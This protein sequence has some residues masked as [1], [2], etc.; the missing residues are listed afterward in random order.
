M[1]KSHLL[2][3]F[4][5][6]GVRNPKLVRVMRM[7]HDLAHVICDDVAYDP[8]FNAGMRKLMEARDCFDRLDENRGHSDRLTK[9]WP[10]DREIDPVTGRPLPAGS[11]YSSARSGVEHDR[12][13]AERH[14]QAMLDSRRADRL[15]SA[16]EL[17]EA[18]IEKAAIDLRDQQQ[19]GAIEGDG[20]EQTRASHAAI[21]AEK[22]AANG[23]PRT[24]IHPQDGRRSCDCDMCKG[25]RSALGIA[26]PTT[27]GPRHT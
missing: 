1:T 27:F 14:A 20:V 7:F 10:E 17:T 8:E 22:I 19:V 5:Y 21:R 24:E 23:G 3:H 18:G 13:G 26:E 15:M 11:P 9:P 12:S 16:T 4:V 25:W 2:P 6:G